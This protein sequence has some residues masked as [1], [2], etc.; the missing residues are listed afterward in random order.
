MKNSARL[1]SPPSYKQHTMGATESK[2]QTCG[3]R[4]EGPGRYCSLHACATCRIT[5]ECATHTCRALH[6]S[7]HVSTPGF[8][9]RHPRCAAKECTNNVGGEGDFCFQAHGCTD[10]DCVRARIPG[11]DCACRLHACAKVG[12]TKLVGNYIRVAG[13]EYLGASTLKPSKWC[14]EHGCKF[15]DSERRCGVHQCR[16]PGCALMYP[17]GTRGCKHHA[18]ATPECKQP[19][20]SEY[21]RHCATHIPAGA[22]NA[23]PSAPLPGSIDSAL[24]PA[25]SK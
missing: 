10:P 4:V 13:S 24:P 22:L 23:E 17:S 20:R 9:G 6:C 11:S 16:F 18:C 19:I 25:E 14:P 5:R 3:A 7:V 15:C 12:C 1:N 2:C 21:A 8:C